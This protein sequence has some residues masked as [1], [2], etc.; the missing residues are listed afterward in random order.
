M[1]NRQPLT[2]LTDFRIARQMTSAELAA[3][4]EERAPT[5]SRWETGARK[6]EK[7]KVPKISE[8]TGIPQS[9]LRP[10]LAKIMGLQ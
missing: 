9:I 7:T 10:D 2:A 6:I 3:Y 5:V 1:G 4:L 8:R